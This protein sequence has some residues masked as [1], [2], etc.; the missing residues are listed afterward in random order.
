MRQFDFAVIGAGIAGASAAFE[1]QSRGR[2]IL[3]ER[4][5]LP[6]Q[7]T[8]G[9]SAA[10]SAESYGNRVVAL[11]TR[12]ARATFEQPPSG[13]ARH[14]LARRCPI[15]WVARAEQAQRLHA[16]AQR[17]I[18]AGAQL[19]P[20]D[21]AAARALFPALRAEPVA[22][23]FVEAR[24]LHLD[25]SGLLD[26]YLAGFRARGGDLA[27]RAEVCELR[28][29]GGGWEL[30]LRGDVA[31]RARVVVDAAGAWADEIASLAGARRIG[32]AVLQRTA[33]TFEPPAGADI[34]SWACLIDA[35][36]AFYVKPEGARLLG[37]PCDETP[38]A[39]CDPSPQE[40]DVARAVERIE[41]A[42]M[43]EIRRIPSRWAGLRSFVADRAPV[44]G[45]DPA[46]PG[47]CWLAAQGGFGV[48]TAPACAR[49]AAAL[50][51]DGELPAD[52][53]ALGLT[54]EMLAPARAALRS[55]RERP[56][57][58]RGFA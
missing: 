23:A 55:I 37:S 53:A 29:I 46:L 35:D 3:L 21:A 41:R 11:L 4:E 14:P 36:E 13:F 2:T 25:V 15:L 44:I 24:A 8:T 27:K 39:P 57:P 28:Q 38:V 30:R 19:E 54:P 58:A 1:L 50:I 16:R 48:M 49:A 56:A 17:A 33:F 51:V 32:L 22:S 6:G 52:L 26:S 45:M 42:T 10:F 40:I 43:L 31:L 7:H 20:I 9:R 47:F 12:A 5:A 18:A 34:A